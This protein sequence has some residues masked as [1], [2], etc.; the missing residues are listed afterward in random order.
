MVFT[1]ICRKPDKDEE[2][3]YVF[4]FLIREKFVKN[5]PFRP[6]FS[7]YCQK[8][9]ANRDTS[10][11][12]TNASWNRSS[13]NFAEALDCPVTK[14]QETIFHDRRRDVYSAFLNRMSRSH[15]TLSRCATTRRRRYTL[16]FLCSSA[17]SGCVIVEKISLISLLSPVIG[18]RTIA[19]QYIESRLK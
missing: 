3:F 11:F 19:L 13:R 9:S 8:V 18:D 7:C 5:R 12:V 17:L 16:G 10:S 6:G 14:P 15:E 4:F 1:V 2:R